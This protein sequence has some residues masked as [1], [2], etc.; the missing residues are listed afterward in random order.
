MRKPEFFL[1]TVLSTFFLNAIYSQP[2][3]H[4]Q[5]RCKEEDIPH[6]T[7]YKISGPLKIDGRLDEPVW[8]NAPK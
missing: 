5:D 8:K 6:Y 2:N 1:G 4:S 3:Y 7:A